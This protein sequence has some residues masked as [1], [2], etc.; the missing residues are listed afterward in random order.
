MNSLTKT[1]WID[2]L[3]WYGVSAVIVAYALVSFQLI[4]TTNSF[5]YFLNLS[6]AIGIIIE[7]RSKK[8]YPEVALNIIWAIIAIA[9][10][11]LKN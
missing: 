2:A 1:W 3:G 7:A 11:L 6:G 10:L 4:S 5:Y 9:S 8:D